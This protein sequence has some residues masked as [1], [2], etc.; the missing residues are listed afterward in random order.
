L[1]ESF[2]WSDARSKRLHF[3]WCSVQLDFSAK[4]LTETAENVY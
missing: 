1:P 3:L 2:D 4:W